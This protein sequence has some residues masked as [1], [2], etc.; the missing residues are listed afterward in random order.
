MKIRLIFDELRSRLSE[1]DRRRTVAAMAVL[2]V[3]GIVAT[4]LMSSGGG[5]E[6]TDGGTDTVLDVA[7]APQQVQWEPYRGVA[8]PYSADGPRDRITGS[9]YAR[10]PQGAVC[11]AM[12]AQ[13]RLSMAPD[14]SWASTVVTVAAPGPGRDAFAAARVMASISS[15]ADPAQ[16]AQ[17]VGFRVTD[18][19][20]S[21]ATI[22]L[23]TRMPDGTLTAA[24]SRVIWLGDDW[25]LALPDPKGAAGDADS[26]PL[27]AL[28]SLD[29]YTSFGATTGGQR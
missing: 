7:A 17:F 11:A 20:D 27:V 28:T 24:S 8:V 5:G 1:L 15:D 21:A 22:W 26:T 3:F 9:G 13:V 4:L 23:A 14:E 12:Q 18:Y 2:L 29:G 19:N 10:T 25:K 16:T 6:T